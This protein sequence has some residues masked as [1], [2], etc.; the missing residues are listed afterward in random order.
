[1]Y[2][3]P[4]NGSCVREQVACKQMYLW[5]LPV[6]SEPVSKFDQSSRKTYKFFFRHSLF[7]LVFSQQPPLRSLSL[8]LLKKW[9]KLRGWRR[10]RIS[11]VS[12]CFVY[13]LCSVLVAELAC[14]TADF[15]MGGVSA[16]VAKTSAA[17]I[18]RI[19]LLIQNQDEMVMFSSM[20]ESSSAH[21]TYRSSRVAWLNLTR[22]FLTAFPARTG[23]RGWF[24]CGEETLP[25]LSVTSRPKPWT[26]LSVSLCHRLLRF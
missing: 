25:T 20:F 12:P 17:P 13:Y 18:E 26:S 21:A 11:L 8:I 22:V 5:C 6:W 4:T 2:D 3:P 23:R 10:R 19:K 15:L 9:P 14:V 1:M 16:A 24:R 7:Q